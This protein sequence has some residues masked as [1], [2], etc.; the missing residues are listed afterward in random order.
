MIFL[1]LEH[2]VYLKKVDPKNSS[3][4]P[5]LLIFNSLFALL[6]HSSSSILSALALN[7]PDIKQYGMNSLIF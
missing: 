6:L 2:A 5:S 3:R 1:F 7:L 4:S